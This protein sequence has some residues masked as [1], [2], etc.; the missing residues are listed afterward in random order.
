MEGSGSFSSWEQRLDC[1]GL[2]NKGGPLLRALGIHVEHFS[3][4]ALGELPGGGQT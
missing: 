3:S 2:K 4:C 1:S